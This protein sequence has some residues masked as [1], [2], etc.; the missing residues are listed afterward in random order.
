[1]YQPDTRLYKNQTR[2][3]RE[4]KEEPDLEAPKLEQEVELTQKYSQN[5]KPEE[6]PDKLVKRVP[7]RKSNET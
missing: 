6:E 2:Q 7:G 5:P 3:N 1:M 4:P